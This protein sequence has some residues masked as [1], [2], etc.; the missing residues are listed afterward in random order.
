[1]QFFK[2]A[3]AQRTTLEEF[4]ADE[5]EDIYQ[6]I[7][8]RDFPTNDIFECHLKRLNTAC[9]SLSYSFFTNRTSRSLFIFHFVL[10]QMIFVLQFRD[11]RILNNIL[12]FTVYMLRD[13]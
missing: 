8:C 12:F 6:A 1:M 5:Y 3:C 4:L 11:E 2:G 13:V 7:T 10:T 9:C